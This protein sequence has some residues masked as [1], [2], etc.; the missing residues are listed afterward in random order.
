MNLIYRCEKCGM[1]CPCILV[2]IGEET[3]QPD[4]CPYSG[5]LIKPK[6]NLL[7]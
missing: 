2:Q 7:S 4:T 3:N 6:W 5:N 1:T